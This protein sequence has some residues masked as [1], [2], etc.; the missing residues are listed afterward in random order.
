MQNLFYKA[1]TAL[2][3]IPLVVAGWFGFVPQK[4]L[5]VLENRISSIEQSVSL[6]AYNSSG[7]GTYRLKSSIG[8][9]DSTVNLAEF[10]EPVSDIPYT[11]TYLNTSVGYGTIEPQIPSKSEFISFTGITQNSDGSAQLT[12]VSR[13]LSRSIS[14]VGCIASSTLAT[15]HGGQSAFILSDSP[16]HFSEYAVKRNDETIS[17]SWTVPTPSAAG[18]PTPKS[19]VDALVNGGTVST[20]AVIVAGTA[21]ETIST[22]QI[23]FYNKYTGKWNK[24][25]ADL[26]STS[27]AVLIGVAQGAGTDGVPFSGGVLIKGLDGKNTGGTAGTLIYV[28]NTAGATSTSAGTLEKPIGFIKTSSGFYFDPSAFS[29]NVDVSTGKLSSDYIATSTLGLENTFGGTGRDGALVLTSGTTTIDLAGAP[30]LVKNYTSISITGTGHLAFSNPHASG[31]PVILRSQG[32]VTL[33]CSPIPCIEVSG[34]GSTSTIGSDTV[35]AVATASPAVIG[36][37]QTN[38][39]GAGSANFGRGGATST[40][41][42]SVFLLGPRLFNKY[43]LFVGAGGAGA[44]GSGGGIGGSGGRGGGALV[45]EVGGALNFTAVGGLRAVGLNGGSG[46]CGDCTADAGQGGG[47]GGGGMVLVVYKA[48]TANTGTIVAT[49]GSGGLAGIFAGGSGGGYGGG[50]GSSLFNKGGDGLQGASHND[51]SGG[52]GGNGFGTTTQYYGY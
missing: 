39:G 23:V 29:T 40:A 8:I 15:R 35:G 44:A 22:G 43:P 5:A 17:G 27:R 28:S 42:T 19:Y 36:F 13:G 50:G 14:T 1:V 41:S 10:K 37:L 2:A 48:L 7:G 9:T 6:G 32:D 3:A 12:G 4:D 18:N 25:D 38:G 31:T 30:M 11:M 45:M 20:D 52:A 51:P 47:G 21:G 26:A 46:Q 33:T 49:G 34:L 24:A 16:C